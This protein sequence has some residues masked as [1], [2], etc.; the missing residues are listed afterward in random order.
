MSG[1][2]LCQ[3]I[4]D[5]KAAEHGNRNNYTAG[6]SHRWDHLYV[7]KSTTC[8]TLKNPFTTH[9]EST[10]YRLFSPTLIGTD[11]ADRPHW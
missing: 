10:T 5:D 2:H 3:S 9:Q 8:G 11:L 1:A 6:I 7:L 4:R